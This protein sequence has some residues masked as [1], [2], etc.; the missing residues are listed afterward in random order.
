V[1][2]NR[3]PLERLLN[4][5]PDFH[6]HEPELVDRVFDPGESYRHRRPWP[7]DALRCYGLD[8]SV[9]QFIAD[10]VGASSHTLETGAGRSSLVFALRAATHT[11]ITP[12]AD[13]IERIR[14]YAAAHGISLVTVTFVAQGSERYLPGR[15]AAPL[16][17][18]LLDGK[19]AFPWPIIDWFYT[20]DALKVDGLLILDDVAMPSVALLTEFL[21][22]DR[23]WRLVKR[24]GRQTVV[25]QKIRPDVLDVAWHTQRW[26]ASLDLVA[27]LRRRL[28]RTLRALDRF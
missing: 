2:A 9:L 19:H 27:R 11:A 28:G 18:V 14:A 22:L 12:S 4:E 24:F 3:D 26:N 16:D 10:H 25:F 8:T 1:T 7:L 15:H 5:R 20:A 21:S 13:E 23:G 6:T 17:L